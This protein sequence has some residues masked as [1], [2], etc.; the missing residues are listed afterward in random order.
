MP[1]W[2]AL[3]LVAIALIAI[4]AASASAA[5]GGSVAQAA[6]VVG[7]DL[8]APSA[9][10]PQ[11]SLDA[12]VASQERAMLCMTNFARRQSGENPLEDNA[13]LEQSARDKSRDIL[14]CDSFSHY[15]CGREFTYWMRATGYL[16]TEC[17][18]AGEN[19]A[20]GA[21]E[22]GTV[23]SIFRA[24][25]RSPTHRKNILGEYTEIGID[26]QTGTLEG[27]SGTHVWTEHFGSHCEAADPAAG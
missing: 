20:W 11:T 5:G 17:W 24:W 16:S 9:Q 7:G 19:L 23:K 14:N 2:I 15:A 27:I 26:L 13:T 10:C 8:I 21:D 25:M 3:I 6:A 22:Y 1:R 4:P 12:A 18:R